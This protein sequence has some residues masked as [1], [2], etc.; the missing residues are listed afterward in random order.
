[1]CP[2]HTNEITGVGLTNVS[3][4]SGEAPR[5]SASLIHS[6]ITYDGA[7]TQECG[8]KVHHDRDREQ[9]L[10]CGTHYRGQRGHA[11][12]GKSHKARCAA[13]RF[14]N[15]IGVSHLKC[16]C[17]W[18]IRSPCALD[19]GIFAPSPVS[20]NPYINSTSGPSAPSI[21]SRLRIRESYLRLPQSS[22][23][24]REA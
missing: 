9:W 5:H 6:L 16:G 17:L 23:H 14:A 4:N 2:R 10:P 7:C 12:S 3:V 24:F 8:W 19:P 11:C 21:C 20:T 1:M 18:T 13:P 22:A 15:G